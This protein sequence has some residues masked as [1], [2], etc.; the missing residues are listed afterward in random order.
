MIY[1]DVEQNTDEWRLLRLGKVTGSNAACYMA[2]D[3]K[4]F[5]EP[6]KSYAL[7]IALEMKTGK[8]AE[9]SF[10]NDHMVRG[11]EQEPI[12]RMRYEQ[13]NFLIVGNGGFFDCGRHGDS[14]DGLILKDGII[15][16]KCVIA[17]THY[18][19]LLRGSFD[20]AYRWQ[21]VSHLDCSER[22]WVDYLSYCSD[23]PEEKQMLVYRI[24]REQ[25]KEELKRLAERR[26]E[27][28]ELVDSTL[29]NIQ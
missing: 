1:H 3:G 28:L 9:Y 16:I 27:F 4:A 10:S 6:A 20:P 23:F 11:Q 17:T 14:P 18:A 26:H 7:K 22:S 2:N 25:F 29:R 12:A 8:V 15:E 13:E 5:G 21:L 24:Y 19:T